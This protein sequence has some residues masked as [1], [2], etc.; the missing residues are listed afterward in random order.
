MAHYK[1]NITLFLEELKA[2]NPQLEKAQQQGRALLWDKTPTS[3][4]ERSRQQAARVK[5]K[6]YVYS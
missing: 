3:A 5:Q 6:P 4:D 1:S 2:K